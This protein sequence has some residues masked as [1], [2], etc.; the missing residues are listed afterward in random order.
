MADDL[1]LCTVEAGVALLTLNRPERKNAW[2][3]SM[4]EQYFD[5]LRA[6]E[7]DPAARAIVVTGA[8]TAFCPGLDAQDLEDIAAGS[9]KPA[10]ADRRPATYPTTIAKPIIAA[11]NGAC[12]GIGLIQAL[13]C[14]VRFAAAGIK[15]TTAFARR[16]IMAEHGIGWL[17]PRIVGTGRAMDLLLSGRVL[18]AEEA[19]ALGL[20]NRV[21]PAEDLLDAT[22][23]YA[24]DLAANCS[25]IAMA[26]MKAQVYAAAE[27]S[28]EAARLQALGL[29]ADR[30][31]GHPDFGEGIRSF[32]EK[33]PPD[34]EAFVRP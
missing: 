17:L 29:W 19:L 31:K 30:H 21:V 15:M 16:G 26:S 13:V 11:L 28:L 34:F 24:R 1:V 14:D 32:V 10:S 20:V 8:G 27:S 23:A 22:V 5:L 3:I 18:L 2:T 25:P 6:C 12:A 7:R 4:E 33:R 9:S